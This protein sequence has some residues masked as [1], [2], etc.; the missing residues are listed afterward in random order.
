MAPAG[1]AAARRTD[2]RGTGRQPHIGRS[3]SHPAPGAGTAGRPDGHAAA[4]TPGPC[5]EQPAPAHIPRCAGP[6]GARTRIH[7]AQRHPR[8]AVHAGYGGWQPTRTRSPGRP[9]RAPALP[10]RR[11]APG[12]CGQ[13]DHRRHRAGAPGSPV[14]GIAGRGGKPGAASGPG[15][16][17]RAARAGLA[18]RGARP[19]GI[20]G[21]GPCHTAAAA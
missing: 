20:A 9:H 14:R 11:N 1:L 16:R 2:R 17:A 15:P 8:G 5:G 10:A 6:G 13:R 3:T 12:S 7:P 21:A 19:A 18:G 4:A